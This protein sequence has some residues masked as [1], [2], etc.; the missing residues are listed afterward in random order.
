MSQQDDEEVSTPSLSAHQR[1]A[2]VSDLQASEDKEGLQEEHMFMTNL[3][4][5]TR[6]AADNCPQAAQQE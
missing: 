2:E 6:L 1:P 4:I 5:W 3:T